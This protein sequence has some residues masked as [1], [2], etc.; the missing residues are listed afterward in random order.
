MTISFLTNSIGTV[1]LWLYW[2]SFNGAAATGGEQHRA[3][4]NTYL[5]LVACTII[6][7]AIS[8]IVDK[9]GKIEMVS[10]IHFTSIIDLRLD[11]RACVSYRYVING[12]SHIISFYLFGISSS[13]KCGTYDTTQNMLKITIN[14]NTNTIEQDNKINT[15]MSIK[16]TSYD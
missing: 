12:V 7:F 4:I 2:P 11:K 15:V 1:F 14:R 8:S 10:R 3:V 5:S 16:I 13:S 6:T 9:D